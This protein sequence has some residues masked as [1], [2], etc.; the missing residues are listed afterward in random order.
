MPILMLY[1]LISF[2]LFF[3]LLSSGYVFRGNAGNLFILMNIYL[4]LQAVLSQM[5]TNIPPLTDL[6]PLL[7]RRFLKLE[8]NKLITQGNL[9]NFV[10]DFRI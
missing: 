8:G 10:G 6:D 7:R 5:Q 2:Q 4:L 9:I 1:I 3:F